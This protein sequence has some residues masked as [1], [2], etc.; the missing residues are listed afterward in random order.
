M[1]LDRL[2]SA[3]DRRRIQDTLARLRKSDSSHL[4]L[5]DLL[6]A[7]KNLAESIARGDPW[8]L[9]GFNEGLRL[10]D[11]IEEI[12][13]GLSMDGRR[14]LRE[15]LKEI[16]RDFIAATYDPLRPDSQAAPE[17]EIGWWQHRIPKFPGMALELGLPELG[18]GI[19]PPY[20]ESGGLA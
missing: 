3:S 13:E 1:G 19:E 20:Q 11:L 12:I 5:S 14:V 7:W 15:T 2:F 10:R 4:T 6:Q 17:T 16:D 8:T 18:M 9:T